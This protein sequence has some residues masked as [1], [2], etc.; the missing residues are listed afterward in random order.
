MAIRQEA[1]SQPIRAERAHYRE[2]LARI[3]ALETGGGGKVGDMKFQYRPDPDPDW[4][5]ADFRELSRTLA[6]DGKELF[7]A[8]G[9]SAGV[10]DGSTT[11]N[12]PDMRNRVPVGPN[13]GI[14]LNLGDRG[15]DWDHGHTNPNT[16]A[17]V[18][19]ELDVAGDVADDTVDID[20]TG[21]TQELDVVTTGGG[22]EVVLAGVYTSNPAQ[23]G[24]GT[25]KVTT[26]QGSH[27]HTQDP[28]G[29]NNQAYTCGVWV[30]KYR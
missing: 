21:S 24:A 6:G 27:P 20:L 8:I 4:C 13:A 14:G 18:L 30:I 1:K 22:P 2:L 16:N 11:F 15:G 10:G 7:E 9:E 12:V 25:L 17:A 3:I 19:P 29:P 26:G 23:H 5:F 28:T